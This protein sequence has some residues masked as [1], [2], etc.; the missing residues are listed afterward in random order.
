M[1]QNNHLIGDPTQLAPGF[2]YPRA[3]WITLNRIRTGQGRFNYL[4]HKWE[5]V[6]SPLCYHGQIQNIKHIIEELLKTMF[7]GGVLGLRKGGQQ[8]LAWLLNLAICLHSRY[9]LSTY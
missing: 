2:E 7:S 4:I 9:L 5:M 6:D 3:A 1:I 8:V